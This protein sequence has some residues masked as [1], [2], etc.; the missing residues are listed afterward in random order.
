LQNSGQGIQNPKLETDVGRTSDKFQSKSAPFKYAQNLKNLIK[1]VASKTC[2][3]AGG[4]TASRSYFLPGEW[5]RRLADSKLQATTASNSRCLM[6]DSIT[7]AG[8][9]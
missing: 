3:R 2:D 6:K 4:G 5:P 1:I 8:D 9:D 7:A